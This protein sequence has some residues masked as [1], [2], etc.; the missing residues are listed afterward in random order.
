MRT[1]GFTA[2]TGL[3]QTREHYARMAVASNRNAGEL[4]AALL[5]PPINGFGS[6][7]NSCST[8]ACLTVGRCRARVTCCQSFGRCTCTTT[9]C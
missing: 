8:S 2:E 5:A 3:T 7:I 9:P 4:V 6:P 1:P